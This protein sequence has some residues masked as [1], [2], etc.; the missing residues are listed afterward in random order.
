MQSGK[1]AT[2]IVSVPQRIADGIESLSATFK[3]SPFMVM[4]AALDALLFRYS[5]A[6]DISVGTPIA[7][8]NWLESEHLIGALVNTL[9]MRVNV[10][11]EQSFAQLLDEA[12]QVALDAYA[13][14]DV[15]FATL[16]NELHPAR[17]RSRTPLFQVFLNVQN[18]PFTV[19]ALEGTEI[20]VMEIERG[21]AQF[22]LSVSVDLSM[23]RTVSFEY[24]TDLFHG[25][26][27]D[28][29]AA[30][31]WTLLDTVIADPDLPIAQV[32]ILPVGER[33][34]LEGRWWGRVTPETAEV[35]VHSMVER[36]VA[37][38]PDRVA[39]RFGGES[40]TYAELDARANRL[41]HHLIDGGVRA[42]DL[43][44]VH[45]ERSLEMVVGVLG[46]LKAGAGYVPIDPRL[47]EARIAFM[48]EDT[49][50]PAVV[51]TS[52]GAKGLPGS[53]GDGGPRLVL[54]DVDAALIAAQ[55]SGRRLVSG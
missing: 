41:A 18:A 43:V 24:S 52:A 33:V 27:I 46:V 54:V 21:A 35:C 36:Q 51:T 11:G 44:A 45:L 29:M 3:A 19:P 50:A 13:N 49:A 7:N 47:P 6:T 31:L 48:L 14:Q 30:H 12:R 1:G 39:V 53:G 10:D 37:A 55:P 2:F 38:T 25:D 34:A 9:V 5:G 23:K 8:R 15:S 4:L 17:D 26:R 16:V 28:R 20:E 32:P 42:G 40:L 22:D